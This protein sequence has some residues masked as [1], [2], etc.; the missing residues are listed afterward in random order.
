MPGAMLGRDIIKACIENM[1]NE[2]LQLSTHEIVHYV[3]L[4]M[5]GQESIDEE[6]LY[7]WLFV[8][9][10]IPGSLRKKFQ[11]MMAKHMESFLNAFGQEPA[12]AIW[13]LGNMQSDKTH[14]FFEGLKSEKKAFLIKSIL[15]SYIKMGMGS[16]LDKIVAKYVITTN[17][18]ETDNQIISQGDSE[19]ISFGKTMAKL[20]Y[21]LHEATLSSQAKED[22]LEVKRQLTSFEASAVTLSHMQ[23]FEINSIL[24]SI[25]SIPSNYEDIIIQDL[26]ETKSILAQ[27]ITSTESQ[28][29][30]FRESREKQYKKLEDFEAILRADDRR[31]HTI[32]QSDAHFSHVKRKLQK[33][34]GLLNLILINF[35]NLLESY[36]HQEYIELVSD[37]SVLR[38]ILIDLFLDRKGGVILL[39]E[40][41]QTARVILMQLLFS[42]NRASKYLSEHYSLL[43]SSTLA[44]LKSSPKNIDNSR[45]RASSTPLDNKLLL[46]AADTMPGRGSLSSSSRSSSELHGAITPPTSSPS[47]RNSAPSPSQYL[48]NSPKHAVTPKS[49]EN[50]TMF[51]AAVRHRQA[52]ALSQTYIQAQHSERVSPEPSTSSNTLPIIK[53]I[54]PSKDSSTVRGNGLVRSSR[55][56]FGL[57]RP[58]EPVKEES[59]SSGESR[60]FIIESS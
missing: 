32:I 55:Y 2:Q 3:N 60:S 22:K 18:D 33:S 13:T 42:V 44:V 53:D 45:M 35:A 25:K 5:L 11:S 27:A 38:D 46:S 34:Q 28:E 43:S 52:N 49:S 10:S 15:K 1:R 51:F 59:E 30:G 23:E 36:N 7:L 57:G 37:L 50:K 39:I 41:F 9:S 20:V 47:P 48:E 54:E 17:Q 12:C 31:R 24:S 4:I 19:H 16:H 6:Q 8:P 56:D 21:S 29:I 14:K 58:I 40:H 26:R